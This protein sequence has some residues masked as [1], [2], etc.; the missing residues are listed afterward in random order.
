M[1][2]GEQVVEAFFAALTRMDADELAGCFAEDGVYHSIPLE[3]VVGREAIRDHFAAFLGR[4]SS[5]G[6]TVHRQVAGPSGELVFNE[7]VDSVRLR[8]GRSV[9]V[10]VVGVFEMHGGEIT[11][12]R[13]YFDL[14]AV[15]GD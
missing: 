10:P 5:L 6:V 9:D 3:P 2:S 1:S 7:R 4:F 14:G 11:A 15:Q 12:W 8:T 13:D